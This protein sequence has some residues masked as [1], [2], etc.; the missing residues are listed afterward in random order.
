LISIH[1]PYIHQPLFS[2]YTH[3]FAYQ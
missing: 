2:I 1:T 3:T